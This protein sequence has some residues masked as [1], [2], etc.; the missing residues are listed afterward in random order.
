MLIHQQII[1]VLIYY[2]TGSNLEI[3]LSV[4]FYSNSSLSLPK[5]YLL[6][7]LALPGRSLAG[8]TSEISKFVSLPLAS[9]EESP[10][11]FFFVFFLGVVLGLTIFA[12]LAAGGLSEDDFFDFSLATVEPKSESSLPFEANSFLDRPA[13]FGFATFG[14]EGFISSSSLLHLS[15]LS[16]SCFFF[17]FICGFVVA[18]LLFFVC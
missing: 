7:V 13:A 4:K 9:S 8:P 18:G 10:N 14:G 16:T 1:F 11:A 3:S 17:C 15:E 5:L 12:F 6:T 2:K